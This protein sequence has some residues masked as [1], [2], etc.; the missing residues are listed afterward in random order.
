MSTYIESLQFPNGLNLEL[1]D[2]ITARY[3]ADRQ[4]A[5]VT[6]DIDYLV[7]KWKYLCPSLANKKGF[8]DGVLVPPELLHLSFLAR[9]FGVVDGVIFFQLINSS[10][11]VLDKDG[12]VRNNPAKEIK[13]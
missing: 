6:R 4:D 8:D 1:E 13:Q 3:V 5:E 9:K 12:F 11:I 10:Q 2:D 7:N